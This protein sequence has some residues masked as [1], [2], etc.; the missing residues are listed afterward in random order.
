M[1]VD[2]NN[3]VYISYTAGPNGGTHFLATYDGNS[4]NS[5]QMFG[6]LTGE[7]DDVRDTSLAVD[8]NGKIHIVYYTDDDYDG[9]TPKVLRYVTNANPSGWTTPVTIDSSTSDI[10]QYPSIA[11]D[12][13]NGIHISYYDV[14]NG[15]L[16]YGTCS[17][18]CTNANN[19]TMTTV[20]QTGDVG[21]Y[22]SIALDSNNKTYI[23][24]HDATNNDLKY[25]DN[26]SGYWKRRE[27][28][29]YSANVGTPHIDIYVDGEFYN[30]VSTNGNYADALDYLKEGNGLYKP[31]E[32]CEKIKMNEFVGF[33]PTNGW[34]ITSVTKLNAVIDE[35]RFW[36]IARTQSQLQQ[37]MNQ[38]LS[39][40][41]GVC[42]IGQSGLIGYWRFNE[43]SGISTADHSGSGNSG[44]KV[45]CDHD[46][47]GPQATTRDWYGG[48][49]S[50]KSF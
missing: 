23:T 44:S 50:G 4:W 15:N 37:C 38:E 10:G 6:T 18:S 41:G 29:E 32:N 46:C 42:G 34:G 39:I 24:Y 48:W 26:T 12:S 40:T 11:L 1:G 22:T 20:D 17:S 5:H 35:V 43:G 7:W 27:L 30:C 13:N 25:T 45:Y 16:K 21:Q 33:H 14:G 36:K 2:S 49:V 3:N 47:L 19:W 9:N 28:F 31:D 8:S